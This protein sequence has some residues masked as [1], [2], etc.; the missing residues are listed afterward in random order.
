VTPEVAA[1]IVNYN[2]GDHLRRAL[3]SFAEEASGRP[4]EAIVV[5]N[6]SV[7]GSAAIVE[8]FAPGARLVVNERNVGFGR[9]IN[10][11]LA[12]STAPLVLIMNPDCR[13]VAGSLTTLEAEL[14]SNDECAIVGPRILDPD[15]SVQGSAR[16][17]P[18]MLTGLFGRRGWLRR[19]LPGLPVSKRN[20][21]ADD[22]VVVAVAQSRV[23][24][25]LSGACMLA[26]RQPLMTVRGFD[27]RYFLYWED[28]DLC[29]RLRSAGHQVRYVPSATAVHEVGGSSRSARA[30]SSRAFHESAYRYYATHVAPGPFN[31]KR[32]VA[33][34]LLW[35]RCWFQLRV[36]R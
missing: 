2:S 8:E 35:A 19:V 12:A 30:L 25:W 24:D 3:Q 31:P 18:D 14:L 21:V 4:W 1:L 33:R 22:A 11:A 28:A 7:D 20:V 6:A 9:G 16:G 34:I 36:A 29:R 15:G 17:D 27:E 26:R 5:D 13:L 32:L 23:V 10:Q